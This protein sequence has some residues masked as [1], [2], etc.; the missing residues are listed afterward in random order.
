MSSTFKVID[1]GA[2]NVKDKAASAAALVEAAAGQVTTIHL[3]P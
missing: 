2:F 1:I 3:Q